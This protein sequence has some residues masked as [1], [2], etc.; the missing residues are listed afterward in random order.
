MI[1][2][3]IVLGLA[4]AGAPVAEGIGLDLPV[5]SAIHARGPAQIRTTAIGHVWSW[6]NGEGTVRAITDDDGVVRAIDVAPGAARTVRFAPLP[7]ADLYFNELPLEDADRAVGHAA[8]FT[9][10]SQLPDSQTPAIA[11]GYHLGN[12]ELVLFF[13]AQHRVLREAFFGDRS[14]L[15]R[16][17]LIPGEGEQRSFS[18][19]ALSR[20][21]G[22]DYASDEQG[23]AYVRIAVGKDGTVSNASIYISSGHADLDRIAIANAMQAV[24]KPAVLDGKPVSA[25]YFHREDFVQ[26]KP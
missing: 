2:A 10:A 6:E 14:A 17:G 11:R 19:P 7:R 22:A 25:V 13:E 26:T 12:R 21:G 15:A 20:P 23:V 1:A 4:A 24:F 8:W 3:A 18:A 5:A 9:R 16:V